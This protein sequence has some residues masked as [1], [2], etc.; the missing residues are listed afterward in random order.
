MFQPAPINSTHPIS[1]SRTHF[2]V[3]TP[4]EETLKHPLHAWNPLR[5]FVSPP[6]LGRTSQSGNRR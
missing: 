3:S 1:N 4:L 6:P 5:D 2:Q